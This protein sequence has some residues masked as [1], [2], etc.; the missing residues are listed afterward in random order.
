MKCDKETMGRMLIVSM[1]FDFYQTICQEND[2]HA[3]G[4]YA[5]FQNGKRKSYLHTSKRI[6]NSFR[7]Q[8]QQ[9]RRS[10]TSVTLWL[11]FQKNL[12]QVS[13][14]RKRKLKRRCIPLLCAEELSEKQPPKS[15]GIK[16]DTVEND[17][18][19]EAE[20]TEKCSD[21]WEEKQQDIHLQIDSKMKTTRF[22]SLKIVKKVIL[23]E[24]DDD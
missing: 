5:C 6:W 19:N 16:L 7:N 11:L 13:I 2:F 3:R 22:H 18:N 20:D 15:Y 14:K 4:L 9:K 17:K 8:H 24:S 21:K 10:L 1:M 12:H 23:I